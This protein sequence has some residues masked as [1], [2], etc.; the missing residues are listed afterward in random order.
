MLAVH[1]PRAP[2][3]GAETAHGNG[4]HVTVSVRAPA[5]HALLPDSVYPL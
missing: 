1:V 2:F 5:K 3:I 4:L